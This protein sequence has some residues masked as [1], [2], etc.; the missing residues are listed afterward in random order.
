MHRCSPNRAVQRSSVLCTI[1]Q[2]ADT[3]I[4]RGTEKKNGEN[5]QQED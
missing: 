1:D 2:A 3:E 5:R 4:F